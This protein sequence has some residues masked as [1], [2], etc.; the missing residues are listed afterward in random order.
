M[1]RSCRCHLRG[2]WIVSTCEVT[3]EY[4]GVGKLSDGDEG[5]RVSYHFF[6]KICV[7]GSDRRAQICLKVRAIQVL[8]IYSQ[9]MYSP[10]CY[11]DGKRISNMYSVEDSPTNSMLVPLLYRQHIPNQLSFYHHHPKHHHC[12]NKKQGKTR[13]ANS[14]AIS[15]SGRWY[16]ILISLEGAKAGSNSPEWL[17]RRI[18][19]GNLW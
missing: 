2:Y 5:R 12:R 3:A 4:R 6:K 17:E 1:L 11:F 9:N 16:R 7:H 18:P 8:E 13:K 10:D 14:R 15:S 19:A